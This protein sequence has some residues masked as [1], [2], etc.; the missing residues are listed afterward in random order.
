MAICHAL[1]TNESTNMKY[2]DMT[3]TWESL[4]PALVDLYPKNKDARDELHRMARIA[5]AY[6]REMKK[7]KTETTETKEE[8]K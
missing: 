1:T 8:R 7:Q 5:D 3:P 4:L 6:V 2:I